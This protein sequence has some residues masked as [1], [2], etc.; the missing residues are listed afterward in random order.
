MSRR[1]KLGLTAD[2]DAAH[3]LP[4]YQG[5][6]A[7]LHGHTYK[8]EVVIEGSVGEKGFVMDFYD[9]KKVLASV[10]KDLDHGCLNDL[11]QNP[12]AELIAEMI[13]RRM[14]QELK[15]SNAKL[16]SLKLWEGQNKWV[17]IEE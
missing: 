5:K 3:F 10:L 14:R 17:M 16:V 1:M 11:L 12:T 13:C 7:N 4:G 2:F 6:C 9:L 15:E 8:V